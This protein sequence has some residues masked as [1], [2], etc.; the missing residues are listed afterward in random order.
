[1]FAALAGFGDL[2]PPAAGLGASA[3]PIA[4]AGAGAGAATG[5]G[6]SLLLHVSAAQP[7]LP[8]H[9][10]QPLQQQLPAAAS[11]ATAAT[12]QRLDSFSVHASGRSLA[13]REKMLGVLPGEIWS[14]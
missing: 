12:G 10:A 1:V 13:D 14:I 3:A 6:T 8:P 9:P 5:N 7:P 2:L 11:G 4:G